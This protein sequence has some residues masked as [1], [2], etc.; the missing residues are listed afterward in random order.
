MKIH[1][2]RSLGQNWLI[3]PHILDRVVEAAEV[4]KDDVILEVGPGTGLLTEKLSLKAKKVIAIEKDHRLIAD[5]RKKF[6]GSNVK[7]IESD[8]LEF[9]PHG[10]KLHDTSY[11]IV[12]NLPYYI[13]SNFL[14]NVFEK[15]PK[16]E[17]LVLTV[18]KE[19][20]KRIKARPPNMNLLALSVQYYSDPKIIA[21]ISKNNFRPIPKVDSAII[22]LGT[23]DKTRQETEKLFQLIRAGFSEKRKL[24]ASNL[25][26]NLKLN[27]EKV[28]EALVQEGIDPKA[29]AENLSL[30]EWQNLAEIL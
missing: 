8:V 4:S 5:L 25:S 3:N 26:K 13:T 28:F 18:Q 23:R 19:V 17:L 22:R 27:K 1:A 11:K 2:K 6:E 12:A 20:A 29:R 14:R 10:F 9:N 15:W 30:Q 16:P 24:L 21:Y 7:I